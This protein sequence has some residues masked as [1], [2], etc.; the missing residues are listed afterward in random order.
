MRFG[1]R[2][3]NTALLVNSALPLNGPDETSARKLQR[4]LYGLDAILK[5]RCAQEDELDLV[6]GERG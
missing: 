5:Q 3:L 1:F 6:L 2:F 4:L